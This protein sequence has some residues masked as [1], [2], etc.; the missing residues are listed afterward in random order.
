MQAQTAKFFALMKQL[1][2]DHTE[3]MRTHKFRQDMPVRAH[4]S[5]KEMKQKPVTKW[6]SPT[7]SSA[8]K[9]D[10]FTTESG[11]KTNAPRKFQ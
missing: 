10:F 2:K 4:N 9:I 11:Q 6:T 8:P 5:Q 7:A 1:C 3:W